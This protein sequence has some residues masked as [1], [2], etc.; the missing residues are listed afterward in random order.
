MGGENRAAGGRLEEL[1][2]HPSASDAGFLVE[3]VIRPDM[4]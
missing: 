4:S 1:V 2:R 3:E